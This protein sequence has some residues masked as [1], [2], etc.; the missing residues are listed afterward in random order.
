MEKVRYFGGKGIGGHRTPEKR[1][2]P[3]NRSSADRVPSFSPVADAP[4][5]FA[6]ATYLVA[7]SARCFSSLARMAI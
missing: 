6:L 4:F 3:L 1:R 2:Y 7:S 5:A